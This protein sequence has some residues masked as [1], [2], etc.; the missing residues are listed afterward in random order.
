MLISWILALIIQYLL[1]RAFIP[2]AKLIWAA[3]ALSAVSLGVSIPSSPGN[4]GVY[5]ASIT[6]ALSAFGID[7]SLAFSYALVSHILS[8][9]ITTVLGSYSLVNEGYKLGD[10]W[11]LSRDHQKENI[12]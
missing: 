5:E 10:I 3:F 7:Q 9:I 4:I 11:R 6:L 1:L 8:L 2:E 12:L